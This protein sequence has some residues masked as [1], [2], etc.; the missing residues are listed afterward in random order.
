MK[1]MKS[2]I[3]IL[4]AGLLTAGCEN[5]APVSPGETALDED[6]II[7]ELLNANPDVQSLAKRG[8]RVTQAPVFTFSDQREVGTSYLARHPKGVVT[9]LKSNELEP[10]TVVT[11]WWVFF[12]E[13]EKCKNGCDVADLGLEVRTD[14]MYADGH[15]IDESGKA[16]FVGRQQVGYTEGSVNPPLLGMPPIG[17]G[18]AEAAEVHLVVRN[19]GPVIPGL[20]EEMTS[21]FGAGCNDSPPSGVLGTPGPNDCADI[22]FAVHQPAAL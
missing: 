7:S 21:T 17:L 18:N 3:L 4:L 6:A 10:G 15:V 16:V 14:V 1:L 9:V 8:V 13:P 12:N 19:H 11:L 22:Q 20:E 2:L 5:E